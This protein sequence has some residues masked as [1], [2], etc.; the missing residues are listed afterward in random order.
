VLENAQSPTCRV[1]ALLGGVF[2]DAVYLLQDILSI[3]L[4][5]LHKLDR[6]QIFFDLKRLARGVSIFLV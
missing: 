2:L 5:I 1:H 3:L 4:E 6:D